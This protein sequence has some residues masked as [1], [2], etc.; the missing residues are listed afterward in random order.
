MCHGSTLAHL[1][2]NDLNQW[3]SRCAG[4]E[5]GM[6]EGQKT[7]QML[8]GEQRGMAAAQ[9][10][11]GDAPVRTDATNAAVGMGHAAGRGWQ[12]AAPGQDS[13]HRFCSRAGFGASAATNNLWL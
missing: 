9:R 8:V 11:L 4:D 10:G 13:W 1:L 2:K 12:E 6:E 5:R 3:V 7:T